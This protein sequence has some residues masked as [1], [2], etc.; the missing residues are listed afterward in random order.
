[1]TT[2]TDTCL[3]A[4]TLAAWVDGGLS[5]TGAAMAEA[6]VSSCPRCQ[7]IAGLIV[8][9]TPAA[10]AQAPWWRRRAAWLVPVS[11]GVAAAGL[12]MIAPTEPTPRPAAPTVTAPPATAPLE[13]AQK[14]GTPAA[15][16]P[17][18][19]EEIKPT[20]TRSAETKPAEAKKERQRDER[21][22]AA[23]AVT[24]APAGAAAPPATAA[25]T[26]ASASA[27][28]AAA[29]AGAP[30][31]AAAGRVA[32]EQ[33]A[34]QTFAK[35]AAKEAVSP[36]GALHWRITDRGALERSTDGGTSWQ[37]VNVG[38]TATFTIVQA[39]EPRT[40]IVTTTDGRQFGTADA[41]ATWKPVP[42]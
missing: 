14:A 15:P 12:L 32:D 36:D 9:T 10:I 22:N 37:A 39:P 30:S 19:A 3:D 25:P 40:A 17:A 16:P 13:S 42:K 6:H 26:P 41:G 38:V 7:A 21:A 27:P 1:M 23:I 28:P 24:Q 2:P 29:P 33:V 5:R 35:T 4:E 11:V 34:R 8:K 18:R 31:A 20:E